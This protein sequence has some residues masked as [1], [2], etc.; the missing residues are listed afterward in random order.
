MELCQKKKLKVLTIFDS[1]S[2]ENCKKFPLDGVKIAFET[3][4]LK[5]VT[6]LEI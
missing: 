3:T 4:N 5:L 1:P 6:I 2:V